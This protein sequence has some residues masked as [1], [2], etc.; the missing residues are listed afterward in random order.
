VFATVTYYYRRLK[1]S[2]ST[3]YRWRNKLI[4]MDLISVETRKDKRDHHLPSLVSVASLRTIAKR[5]FDAVHAVVCP[6]KETQ[7]P[8]L[9]TEALRA[10]PEKRYQPT[11]LYRKLMAAGLKGGLGM[12]RQPPFVEKTEENERK[13]RENE[14]MIE[15]MHALAARQRTFEWPA[16]GPQK[17]EE[18]GSVQWATPLL[19]RK[20]RERR[21]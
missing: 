16:D 1:V 13:Q 21:D 4:A 10:Q 6:T 11:P 9:S 5:M 20:L 14:A 8:V 12:T 7:K 3:Y 17:L 2:R 18:D 19:Q 15:K